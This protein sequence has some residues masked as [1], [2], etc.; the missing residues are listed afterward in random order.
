MS[1]RMK[2]DS[3]QQFR[4]LHL[5]LVTERDEIQSR[6]REIND[7]LGQL[8]TSDSPPS[9]PVGSSQPSVRRSRRPSGRS[10]RDIITELVQDEAKTKEEI[11]QGVKETGYKFTTKNPMNSIGVVLYGKNPKFSRD[12]GKFSLDVEGTATAKE[13][14]GRKKRRL[15]PEGKARIAEA[16]KQ[17]WAARLHANAKTTAS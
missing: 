9:R 8:Q 4:K 13:Q 2:N 15:S 5:Q 3:V 6:L 10:L 12:D 11:L 16:Q 1:T 17:R 14:D 7:A